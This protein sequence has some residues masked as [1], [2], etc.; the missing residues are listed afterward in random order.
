MWKQ[1]SIPLDGIKDLKTMST[2]VIKLTGHQSV[3]ID[4]VQWQ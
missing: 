4:G 3:L 2:L 1:Y